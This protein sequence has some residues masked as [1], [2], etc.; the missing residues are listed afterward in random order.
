MCY[1][2]LVT[3]FIALFITGLNSNSYAKSKPFRI[4]AIFP[5]S[6]P[7]ADH[8]KES[9]NG[10]RLA[11]KEMGETSIKGRKIE[12]I[13]EDNQGDPIKSANAALKLINIEK[14]DALLGSVANV[15]TLAGAPIAQEAQ[16]PLITPASTS[17]KITQMGNFI[18]RIC[19]TDNFQGAAMARFAY[20]NLKKRKAAIIIDNS[21]SYSKEMAKVFK[22]EFE[23]L[24]GEFVSRERSYQQDE[25]DFTA[26]LKEL[27]RKRPEFVFLPGYYNEVGRIL[28]QAR[29]MKINV[30][31]LGGDGWNS[32]KLQELAGANGI[33]NSYISSHFS[34]DDQDPVVQAFVQKYIKLHNKS[35]GT[36]AALGYDSML[37]LQ[38]AMKR[39]STLSP[40]DIAKAI[41]HTKNFKGVTGTITL[42]KFRNASKSVVILKTTA[43]GNRFHI[44]I[45][46]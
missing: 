2:R 35:P 7:L 26:I 27:K 45:N 31:F 32:P 13:L 42:D 24:G 38:D 5:V 39:A 1:V 21:S 3:L 15:N 37:V 41:S 8:G 22:K 34:A 6:G 19:F 11:L 20:H 17:D 23:R 12:L 30:P 43:S 28:R 16:I 4:G 44:K 9:M 29:Q 25:E 33:K 36:M 10:I 14:V 40:Q 46:P 18:S